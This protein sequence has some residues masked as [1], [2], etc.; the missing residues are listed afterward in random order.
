MTKRRAFTLVELLVV[1]GIIAVLVGILLPVLGRARDQANRTRCASNLRQMTMAMV[2]YSKENK[3][4]WYLT[5]FDKNNDSLEA[6]IPGYIKDPKVAICPGTK[7]VVDLRVTATETVNGAP[8]K[9]YPHLRT[10]ADYADDET[11]G[12]SYEVFAFAGTAEYP[13]GVKIKSD[14]LLT[15]KN[16]RKPSETFILL[17]RD[18]GYQNSI[19]NWPEAVDNH[20]KKGLNLGFVDG[21]VEFVDRA[22]MVRAFLVS[23]HPWP[24]D[25]G[26][27]GPALAAVKGLHNTGGWQGKWWY[28]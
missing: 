21:H 16:V 24:C 10:P 22:G 27:L 19:N 13:D 28:Q 14:Y 20:G 11:G 12:H 2:M 15:Y 7:N 25:S 9:Y 4:G 3:G 23:R 1:I 17:D 26:A 8:R 18:Q 6:L 5:V